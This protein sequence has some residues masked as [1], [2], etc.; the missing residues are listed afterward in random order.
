MKEKFPGNR[1]E[2]THISIKD[3]ESDLWEGGPGPARLSIP[4]C[5]AQMSVW[6][7]LEFLPMSLWHDA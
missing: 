3:Y 2:A 4:S 5:L 1:K 6:C 7:M